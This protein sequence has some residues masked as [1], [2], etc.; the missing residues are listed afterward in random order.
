MANIQRNV[1]NSCAWV[2]FY[3]AEIFLA[4]EALHS[5]KV[6]Y[7]DLKPENI[8]IDKSGHIRLIDFGYARVLKGLSYQAFTSCGTLGY[9]APEVLRSGRYE[10]DMSTC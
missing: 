4:L 5:A 1:N 3:A 10:L 6:I 2:R 7:R 8:V 9:T